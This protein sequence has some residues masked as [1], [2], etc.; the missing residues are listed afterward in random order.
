M[1]RF[2]FLA[3][4]FLTGC[5][6]FYSA[7]KVEK[8][9]PI[10]E[11]SDSPLDEEYFHSPT[12]DIAGHIPK[13][14]LQVNT[15]NVPELENIL[16]VY[17]DAARARAMVLVEIPGTAD[18]RRKIERDG[19]LAL[20]EESFQAKLKKHPGISLTRQPEAFTIDSMLFVNYEYS[21][22]PERGLVHN[23]VV[24]FSAGVRFYELAMVELHPVMEQNQYLENF[25][26]LQSVIA[27]LEGVAAV[28]Q[29]STIR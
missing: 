3:F 27:G 1:H 11:F 16:A 13:N 18:L 21:P 22:S 7:P 9:K 25:R 6:L 17:T 20:A 19:I 4:L 28:R 23:R 2:L 29:G 14:W 5:S 8:K 26:L 15:E 12:G 24:A 10:Y